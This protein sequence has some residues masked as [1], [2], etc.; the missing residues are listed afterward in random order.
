MYSFLLGVARVA[1]SIVALFSK[2]INTNLQIRKA[3]FKLKTLEHGPGGKPLYRENLDLTEL[4]EHLAGGPKKVIWFHSASVGEYEQVRV[5]AAELKQRHPEIITAFSFFSKSGYLQ[6]YHDPLPDIFFALPFDFKQN[7]RKLLNALEPVVIVYARYDVWPN[8]AMLAQQKEI[9]QLLVCAT[10]KEKSSRYRGLFSGFYRRMYQRLDH[11]LVVDKNNARRFQEFYP[12]AVIAGDTRFDAVA[13]RIKN[14]VET[15]NTREYFEH[16]KSLITELCNNCK[17]T[18]VAGSS[19]LNSEKLLIKALTQLP[20]LFLILVPH[21]TDTT[22]IE[23]IQQLAQENGVKA[24]TYSE[25]RQNMSEKKPQCL[26]VD[27]MGILVELYSHAHIAWVGGGFEG[28]VHTVPEPAGYGLPVFTGETINN[29]PEA[30]ALQRA[31]LLTTISSPE[32]VKQ[33][34][35]EISQLMHNNALLTEKKKS[36]LAFFNERTGATEKSV[37]VIENYLN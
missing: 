19:Y 25:L 15:Q 14:S 2:S 33:M 5:I 27:Q 6:R 37:E 29:S 21:H 7:M 3:G 10:L 17:T 35:H 8:L 36:I 22:H 23:H 30:L 11:I 20:E 26:I 16:K 18:L 32:N 9:P 1:L 24:V 4:K 34:V 12:N 13:T 31:G 28:S